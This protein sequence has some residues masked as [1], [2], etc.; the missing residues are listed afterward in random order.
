M[1]KTTPF[2]WFEN[3]AEAA[4]DFYVSIFKNSKIT[5][6]FRSPSDT[7]SGK[8][9]T[10][11][12]IDFA[13]NGQSF[14]ALNGGAMFR[15]NPSIS[16]Y[17]TFD[18]AAE[19]QQA[20]NRL[21]D[22][23]FIM[24]PLDKYDWS[25]K[26]GWV[27]DKFGVS[28][29]LTLGDEKEAG[30]KIIPL[31]MFCGAQQGKAEEAIRFYTSVFKNSGAD[32]IVHYQAG[33]TNIDAKVVHARFHLGEDIF[34]AMDSGVAQPF[35]FNEAISIVVNCDTQEEIDYY[36][37]RLTANGGEESQCGWL[38]D[39]FGVSWQVAPANVIKYFSGKDAEKSRR[40]MHAM[41]QMKK[42]IIAD[43]E[44]A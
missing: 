3:N 14:V 5:N 12:T 40:A 36:W 37:Q 41:M 11:L 1:Q 13:L 10:V 24:M 39:K 32:T 27:Q 29:Q 4:A 16:F 6:T 35:T 34:M 20:W 25:K 9:G 44:N 18:D 33:Q 15:P 19:L 42:M 38:K 21:S 7:P 8:A 17:V 26:Y 31:F 30:Q 22:S 28:W 43:L 2:I 23:G